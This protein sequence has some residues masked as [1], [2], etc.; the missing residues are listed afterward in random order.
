MIK[1]TFG[2]IYNVAKTENICFKSWYCRIFG[3]TVTH[4]LE[5]I[6]KVGYPTKTSNLNIK[7]KTDF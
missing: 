7:L 1:C 2:H 6:W 5:I 4:C 3:S